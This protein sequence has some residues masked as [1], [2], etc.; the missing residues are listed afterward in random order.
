VTPTEVAAAATIVRD[1]PHLTILVR[2][3]TGRIFGPIGHV[4][5]RAAK[6]ALHEGASSSKW[7]SQL[8]A[9]RRYPLLDHQPLL[10]RNVRFVVVLDMDVLIRRVRNLFLAAFRGEFTGVIQICPTVDIGACVNG[11]L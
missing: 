4:V 6:E 5:N 11:I 1:T 2:E 9:V 7:P 8:G 3:A 10:Q